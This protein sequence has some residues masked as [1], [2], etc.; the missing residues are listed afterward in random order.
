MGGGLALEF[1][2]TG[3]RSLSTAAALPFQE[4]GTVGGSGGKEGEHALTLRSLMPLQVT[5]YHRL[6]FS[7]GDGATPWGPCN[8]PESAEGE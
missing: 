2:G 8:Q 1:A 6:G 5:F 3:E 7:S 4:G